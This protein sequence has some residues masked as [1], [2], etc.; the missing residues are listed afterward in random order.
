MELQKEQVHGRHDDVDAEPGQV[1]MGA[2]HQEIAQAVRHVDGQP[3]G[4]IVANRQDQRSSSL[5]YLFLMEIEDFD[6]F[7]KAEPSSQRSNV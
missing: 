2:R 1:E 4:D 5:L 6:R 7:S 3:D